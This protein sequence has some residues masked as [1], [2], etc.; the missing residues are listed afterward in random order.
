MWIYILLGLAVFGWMFL[1][2]F[3][4]DRWRKTDRTLL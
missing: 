3:E 2:T 1:L 4:V